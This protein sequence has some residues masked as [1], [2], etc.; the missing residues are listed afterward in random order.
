LQIRCH[1]FKN[2]SLIAEV[3]TGTVN[4]EAFSSAD[5][6]IFGIVYFWSF[7]HFMTDRRACV[8]SHLFYFLFV[9]TGPQ[10]FLSSRSAKAGRYFPLTKPSVLPT[11]DSSRSVTL[12]LPEQPW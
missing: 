2:C 3:T 9:K 7:G 6:Y 5:S 8:F 4:N 10:L 11:S 12:R 1:L